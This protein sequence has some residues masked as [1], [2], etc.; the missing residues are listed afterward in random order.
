MSPYIVWLS[1]GYRFEVT[2]KWYRIKMIQM[3]SF[4]NKLPG[5]KDVLMTRERFSRD[6][7]GGIQVG[8]HV[9]IIRIIINHDVYDKFQWSV[10][11]DQWSSHLIFRFL[12][13]ARSTR[14]PGCNSPSWPR[15]APKKIGRR[16]SYFIST[17]NTTC[18][19]S[20]KKTLGECHVA[21]KLIILIPKINIILI[22]VTPPDVWENIRRTLFPHL[23][24]QSPGLLLNP[25]TLSAKS[26][27]YKLKE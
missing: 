24:T 3:M 19:G 8:T 5:H 18:C 15:G 26:Y 17:I 10:I 1:H 27:P 11:S 2:I 16:Y 9:S 14:Q 21:T 6:R 22:V 23:F 4:E 12:N 20:Y 7:C 25:P 13:L